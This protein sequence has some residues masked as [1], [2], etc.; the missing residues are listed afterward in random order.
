[1]GA[2]AVVE[3]LDRRGAVLH[4]VRVE[5]FPAVIGRAYTC[6]VILDDRH[7]DARHAQIALDEQGALIVEDL[8]SL[9][10]MQLAGAAGRTA[11]L[12]V[13]GSV[14]VRLGQTTMRISDA[15]RAVAPAIPVQRRG[16]LVEAVEGGRAPLAIVAL[17]LLLTLVT[18]WLQDTSNTS[19]AAPLGAAVGVVAVVAMWAGIW[20][21]AGRINIHRPAFLGHLALSWLF[22]IA[23]LGMGLVSSYADFLFPES[24]ALQALAVLGGIAMLLGLFHQQLG[25]A[26]TLT[27][28]QR[29]VRALVAVGALVLLGQLVGKAAENDEDYVRVSVSLEPLP[30]ALVPAGTP[31]HFLEGAAGLQREVDRLA[32]E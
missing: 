19:V 16:R 7:V 32:E 22:L 28:R 20:A 8:G 13:A 11:R 29:L 5:Q 2:V 25:L 14:T 23:T 17:G 18:V 1:M 9:N 4:R 10:G 27:G 21:I 26:T 3:V 31:Q 6:A 30:A 12:T 15:D 24:L